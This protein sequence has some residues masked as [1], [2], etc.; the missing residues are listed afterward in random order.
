[1]P[2][3]ITATLCPVN[4]KVPVIPGMQ[5]FGIV[6]VGR[7]EALEIGSQ[8]PFQAPV[9]TVVRSMRKVT[10]PRMNGQSLPTANQEST[11]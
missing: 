7:P 3:G 10:V 5:T 9:A 4:G 6:A 2:G 1:M 8:N 11:P